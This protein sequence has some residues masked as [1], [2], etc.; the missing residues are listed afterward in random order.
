MPLIFVTL[1]FLMRD[2]PK[3]QIFSTLCSSIY[4]LLLLQPI[5]E[6]MRLE[7]VIGMQSKI[8]NGHDRSFSK[9]L[10]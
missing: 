9:G 4:R 10:I 3:S 2:S 8:L 6:K 7:M 5:P 1:S